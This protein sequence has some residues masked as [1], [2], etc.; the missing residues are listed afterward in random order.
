MDDFDF[1]GPTDRPALVAVST[2][3]FQ[4]QA[5]KALVELGYKVHVVDNHALFHSRFYQVNYLVIIIEEFFGGGSPEDNASLRSLQTMPM[6]QRRHAAILLL[7]AAFETLNEM[8]SFSQ[9]VQCVVNYSEIPLLGQ[10]VEKVVAEND[11]FLYTYRQTQ[12]TVH[13]KSPR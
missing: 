4:V 1:I 7:G 13:L 5:T 11:L 6:G 9:S 2:R 8:Q 12:H 10:L 3:E